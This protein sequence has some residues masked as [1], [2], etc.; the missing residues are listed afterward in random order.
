MSLKLSVDYANAYLEYLMGKRA[1][2]PSAKE[3]W[4]GLST[5]DPSSGTFTEC[6]G[7]G[8]ARKLIAV[9]GNTYVDYIGEASDRSIEN[10]DQVVFPKATGAYTVKGIG[11]FTAESGGAPFAYGP[12]TGSNTSVSV[13]KDALPMFEIGGLGLNM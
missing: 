5:N 10:T 12:L 13:V 7:N 8:Y 2:L 3:V 6:S 9:V 1:S 11:L 4:V